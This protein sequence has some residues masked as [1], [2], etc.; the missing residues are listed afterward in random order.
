MK[1][2][3]SQDSWRINRGAT[4]GGDFEEVEAVREEL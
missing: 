1:R 2:K 3:G 4:A